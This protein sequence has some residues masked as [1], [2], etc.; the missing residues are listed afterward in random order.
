MPK[1][2]D[3]QEIASNLP[4]LL[5]ELTQTGEDILV[6]RDGEPVAR[7]VAPQAAKRAAV[8]R[9]RRA[10]ARLAEVVPEVPEEQVNQD[11]VQAIR[12]VREAER[13]H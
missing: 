2:V 7:V 10:L 5:D 13:N 11:V 4:A 6:E 12:E 1:V 8:E 3:V 9:L